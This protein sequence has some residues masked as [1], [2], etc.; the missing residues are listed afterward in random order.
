MIL[1]VVLAPGTDLDDSLR[2]L[3]K[4]TLKQ[5]CSPRH[6][7]ALIIKVNELPRTLTGKLAE[8][9]VAEIVAGRPVRNRDALAN[10]GALD[11]IAEAV[12]RD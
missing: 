11:A 8:I 12:P 2:S 9:S 3:I 1:L 6:I 10:P 5:R 7:P 4:S